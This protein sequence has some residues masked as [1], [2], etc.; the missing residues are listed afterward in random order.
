MQ[1]Y[2]VYCLSPFGCDWPL[3]CLDQRKACQPQLGPY[4]TP[5]CTEPTRDNLVCDWDNS[6]AQ[7]DCNIGLFVVC[8]L[9]LMGSYFPHDF[10]P[11]QIHL[12][13]CIVT[14]LPIAKFCLL[15]P[16]MSVKI[17]QFACFQEVKFFG[18][19]VRL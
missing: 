9:F 19:S 16:K 4:T 15:L 11:S 7:D 3:Q 8:F 5:L 2:D 6:L 14:T 18:M 1:C 13:A 12:F 17:P 10:L